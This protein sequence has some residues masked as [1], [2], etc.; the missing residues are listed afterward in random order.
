MVKQIERAERW[1]SAQSSD[2][3]LL[4]ALGQ[5]CVRQDLWGKAQNY[6]DASI[7]IEPTPVAHLA[8]AQLH[9]KLGNADAV[10]RHIWAALEL[11]LVKLNE[12]NAGN[13]L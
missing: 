12:R 7:S 6:L 8:A 2:A 1:L 13:S 4:F 11:A 9:Q 10:R 3:S 5:L